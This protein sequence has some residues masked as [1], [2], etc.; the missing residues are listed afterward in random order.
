MLRF[1]YL[2]PDNSQMPQRIVIPS[3]NVDIPIRVSP[4]VNGYW[5]V[6]EKE[7]G[8]GFGSAPPSAK[9]GNQV[10]FAH[11][12]QGLFGDLKNLKKGQRVYVL[13]TSQWY[14]YE[15]N[16]SQEVDPSNVKVISHTSQQRLTLFTCSG[17]LDSK[18]L[19]V[20]AKPV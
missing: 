3:I 11:A 12:R 7:A 6:F 19:I 17:F 10:I 2:R 4:L 9:E 18:R 5:E 14:V 16:S 15:V 8:F 20:S 13:T 1:T